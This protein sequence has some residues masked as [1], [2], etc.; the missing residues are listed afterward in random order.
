MARCRRY[1]IQRIV[2]A[3]C[4]IAIGWLA[5]AR[6]AQSAQSDPH[7]NAGASPEIG[8]VT[9]AAPTPPTDAELAGNSLDEFILHHATTHYANTPTTGN[10][11]RWRGGLQSICPQTVGPTPGY[12]AFVT[13]RVR[14]LAT[15][16]G[17]PF[18]IGTE[19]DPVLAKQWKDKAEDQERGRM[20]AVAQAEQRARANN[21]AAIGMLF[22]G[23]SVLG[24]PLFQ[25]AP[26][27]SVNLNFS[28]SQTNCIGG[29]CASIVAQ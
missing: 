3:A 1:G 27:P 20:L 4:V 2:L 24:N 7:V 14:A 29:P 26:A 5:T 12:A 9:V 11:A 25:A 6:A 10:L 28:L 18:G 21:A 22:F 8:D 13:A 17:A 16:V 15:Y 23:L 19:K